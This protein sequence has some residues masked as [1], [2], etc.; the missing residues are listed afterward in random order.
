MKAL[1]S[2][3]HYLCYSRPEFGYPLNLSIWAKYQALLYYWL[4]NSTVHWFNWRILIKNWCDNVP[5][6]PQSAHK[7]STDV[8]LQSYSHSYSTAV[9]VVLGKIVVH[10]FRENTNNNK[11]IQRPFLLWGRAANR[12]CVNHIHFLLEWS[13][14]FEKDFW[15]KHPSQ[16]QKWLL[17]RTIWQGWIIYLCI[18]GM[19]SKKQ[20]FTSVEEYK[21]AC[22]ECLRPSTKCMFP[23][24][25]V[26]HVLSVHL[27][28]PAVAAFL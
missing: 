2:N 3:F 1:E 14:L 16:E 11:Q 7:A 25:F 8:G 17:H 12:C 6:C 20:R 26:E 23:A 28:F 15:F 21:I 9:Q 13:Y 19:W 10:A 18:S 24:I 27:F 5:Y 4:L 22:K